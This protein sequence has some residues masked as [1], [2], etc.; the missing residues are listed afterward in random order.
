MQTHIIL[1]DISEAGCVFSVKISYLLSFKDDGLKSTNLLD[2]N[3][4]S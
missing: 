4:S 2:F 3:E 1:S